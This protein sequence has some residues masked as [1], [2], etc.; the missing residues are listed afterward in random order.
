MLASHRR[1][2]YLF[3]LHRLNNTYQRTRVV[4]LRMIGDH[5]IDILWIHHRT[6][7]TQELRLERRFDCVNQGDFICH[8]QKGIVCGSPFSEITVEITDAPIDCPYPIDI[9]SYLN[10]LERFTHLNLHIFRF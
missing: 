3:R 10:C 7:S 2:K 8:Y 9:I 1:S 5:I 6:D 4:H